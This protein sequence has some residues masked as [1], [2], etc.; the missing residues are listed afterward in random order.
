MKYTPLCTLERLHLYIVIHEQRY[1]SL[2]ALNTNIQAPDSRNRP[3][4]S[5]HQL[6][7][8]NVAM[9]TA[10]ETMLF[11]DTQQLTNKKGFM[12]VLLMYIN[13]DH[14]YICAPNICI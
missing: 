3:S 6:L 14:H 1:A 9:V 12:A 2:T 5:S 13:V 8:G 11:R 4:C 10:V 7:C